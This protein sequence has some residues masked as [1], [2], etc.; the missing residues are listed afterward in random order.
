MCIFSSYV[1]RI[2]PKEKIFFSFSHFGF[3]SSPS[4]SRLLRSEN[5]T[6]KPHKQNFLEDW[7]PHRP[8]IRLIDP[9]A[10]SR[11]SEN[12][13][14][15]FALLNGPKLLLTCDVRH[16]WTTDDGRIS[17]ESLTYKKGII[18]W[19]CGG[20]LALQIIPRRA[21]RRS[22]SQSQNLI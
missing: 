11:H 17:P 9:R 2:S 6:Q 14:S 19:H 21:K 15:H 10:P 12:V 5:R 18:T 7:G 20:W 1:I 22:T 3:F 16:R 8:H 4:L 13:H